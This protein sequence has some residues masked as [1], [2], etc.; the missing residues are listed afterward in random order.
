M[1]ERS[2]KTQRH[3]TQ[4]SQA[5][6]YL[7]LFYCLPESTVLWALMEECVELLLTESKPSRYD[8][9]MVVTDENSPSQYSDRRHS[10][11]PFYVSL[12]SM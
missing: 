7:N 11:T 3:F 5:M 9:S 10:T 2:C 8:S 12:I 1:E 4:T 6:W